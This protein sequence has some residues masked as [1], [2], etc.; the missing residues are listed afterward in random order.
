MLRSILSSKVVPKMGKVE[1]LVESDSGVSDVERVW[2][3]RDVVG[4]AGLSTDVRV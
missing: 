3:E 1:V 2:K 4:C